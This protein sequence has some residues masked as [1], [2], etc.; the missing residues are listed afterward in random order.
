MES[1][2]FKVSSPTLT[3]SQ[4]LK[5][6]NLRQYVVSP[7]DHVEKHSTDDIPT[8]ENFIFPPAVPS[9]ENSG[10]E[11]T[12]FDFN[13]ERLLVKH[14]SH[15]LLFVPEHRRISVISGDSVA[16]CPPMA[17]AERALQTTITGEASSSLRPSPINS[18]RQSIQPGAPAISFSGRRLYQR[19][20]SQPTAVPEN[21]SL[22]SE[23][24]APSPSLRCSTIKKELFERGNSGNRLVEQMVANSDTSSRCLTKRVS[25]LCMKNFQDNASSAVE[26]AVV[27]K[28]NRRQSTVFDLGS[29]TFSRSGSRAN[30]QFDLMLQQDDISLLDRETDTPPL[31]T[32]SWSNADEYDNV[33][34]MYAKHEKIPM[35]DFGSEIR[36]TMDIDHL[37]N[38]SVLLLDLQETSLEEIFAKIIHEM[39]IQE[40]EFTSEQVRSVLFTQDAGNQFHILSRTVQSIC[41]TGTIGG[42]FDYDQSWIC[43]LCMLNTV[44][45]RHVA[46]ARL[47]HPTNLGRTMQD[48]RFIIIVIAPS[49]AKGTK[50]ALE[51]TRTFATLF[52]DMDIRQ[53]LVMAQTVDQF[54]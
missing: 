37:L 22:G 3:D 2:S 8:L 51:T 35:K 28:R 19:R 25:W 49:R 14:A 17:A 1:Q 13:N 21:G 4:V 15:A 41:T 12:M 5:N 27:S 36:A 6:P 54:R 7:W 50:T 46:I 32:L 11:G 31:D 40:P 30:S 24:L 23:S 34:L 10:S 26:A 20:G 39:D 42:T 52:A 29:E 33:T 45:H 18:R 48:L 9:A 38:K 43:A 44:Q 16:S 53:R 47:S